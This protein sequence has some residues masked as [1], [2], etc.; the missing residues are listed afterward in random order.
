MRT[1]DRIPIIRTIRAYDRADLTPDLV[2]GLVLASMLIPQGMA[3]AELT[4]LPA[5]TGIYTTIAALV[6]YAIVGPN[7]R[8]V[9]G[10]DSSLA[11]VIAAVVLPLAAGDAS[12]AV[13]LASAMSVL[14][15]AACLAA[16]WMRA[17]VITELLSKPVR[18]GYLNGIAVVVLVSQLPKALGFGV[19]ST[20]T[21]PAFLDAL[22]AAVDGQTNPVALALSVGS[23]AVI[24]LLRRVA[25]K[26]P[27]VVVA[28]AGSIAI[29]YLVDLEAL[30]VSLVGS[31]PRGL[32]PFSLPIVD[33]GL[34]PSL[35][36][37]AVLVALVSFADTGA[38]STAT[39]LQAGTA[40]D[41]DSEVK[42]LGVANVASGLFGGFATS[43]SSS[44]T[45]VA[46]SVGAR[47]QVAGLVAAVGV[48]ALMFVVPDVIAR[49]PSPTLAA[50]V[51]TASLSLFD[52]PTTRW[53]ARAR[54]SEFVMLLAAF[55]GVVGVG[56]LEGIGIAV[57]VSLGNFVRKAWWPHSTELG[58]VAG[59]P[60]LHDIERHPD[61]ELVDGLLLLR[62]DA[63]LFFANAAGFGRTLQA[64][65]DGAGRPIRRV[66][67]VANAVTDIDTTG[68][69]ILGHVLTDLERRNMDLW[70]AGLK[71]PVKDR[72]RD[73]GV[74][75]RLGDDRF[76]PNTLA[77]VAAHEAR[78]NPHASG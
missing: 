20:E 74:Y 21:V 73:Y 58:R 28:A 53:L 31:L 25:P 12:Q 7:R 66:V 29:G 19:E 8:L 47:S 55:V 1:I 76:F 11:P 67:V 54:R 10:P 30:G 63:P 27:G 18:V 15:G 36:G 64:A 24:V 13:V 51:I 5:I 26:I 22:V 45:A 35:A 6:G 43:A 69:E 50:I 37:G 75:D 62:F 60:G 41:P 44:R 68:A 48:I 3:Y 78:P 32:P 16:G 77:A 56:V 40:V 4:G 39:S 49:M 72:L 65:I 2:A 34:L 59:V 14:A 17:G 52:W 23:V 42:A 9:L 57:L 46:I 71:G 70:F 38:L 61:A 33:V